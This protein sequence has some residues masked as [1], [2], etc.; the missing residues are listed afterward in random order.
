MI[1]DT[2]TDFPRFY[3]PQYTCLAMCTIHTNRS[4]NNWQASMRIVPLSQRHFPDNQP[5]S[6]IHNGFGIQLSTGRGLYMVPIQRSFVKY[7]LLIRVFATSLSVLLSS[8]S[9]TLDQA[10]ADVQRNDY[11]SGIYLLLIS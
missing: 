9:S 10:I 6:M 1:S 4:R 7:H 2:V 3:F 8:M 5:R 11:V